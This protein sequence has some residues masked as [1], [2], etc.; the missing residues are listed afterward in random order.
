[1]AES[2]GLYRA[3]A[4][5]YQSARP[6]LDETTGYAVWLHMVYITANA[7]ALRNEA[8]DKGRFLAACGV[9]VVAA[10]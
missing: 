1:M 5:G 7:L 3:L 8:F 4:V 9:T 10:T 2:R 6:P